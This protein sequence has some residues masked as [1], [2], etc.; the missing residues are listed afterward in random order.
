MNVEIAGLP[1]VHSGDVLREDIIPDSRLTKTAFAR[2]LGISREA[3]HNILG[4]RSSVTPLLAYKLARLLDTSPEMW[5]NLQ[6][7]Y[8][9]AIIAQDKRSELDRIE[10]LAA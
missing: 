2:Q 8:D 4:R 6:Q 7:A 5:M 1:L 9:L 3:L 10:A